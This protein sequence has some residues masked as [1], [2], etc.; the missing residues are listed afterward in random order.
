MFIEQYFE[1]VETNLQKEHLWSSRFV[2]SAEFNGS[3]TKVRRWK[4]LFHLRTFVK[5]GR[6]EYR[7][8]GDIYKANNEE[9]RIG[10]LFVTR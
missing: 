5:R 7:N 10:R 1:K 6:E 8:G 3:V 4:F 9:K 2:A